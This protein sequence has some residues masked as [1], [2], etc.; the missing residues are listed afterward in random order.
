MKSIVVLNASSE[1]HCGS[2]TSLETFTAFALKALRSTHARSDTHL[3]SKATFC[4]GAGS[5]LPWCLCS[6][7]RDAH[8]PVLPRSPQFEY[9]L[10]VVQCIPCLKVDLDVDH[11]YDETATIGASCLVPLPLWNCPTPRPHS[12]VATWPPVLNILIQGFAVVH[13]MQTLPEGGLR[14]GGNWP[15]A[16]FCRLQSM[17]LGLRRGEPRRVRRLAS[18]WS[19]WDHT[20]LHGG[21]AGRLPLLPFGLCCRPLAAERTAEQLV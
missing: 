1:F 8:G 17:E 13:S 6:V 18:T 15:P 4:Q 11:A 21:G 12:P 5:F 7:R 10:S 19:I 16:V 9:E 3:L 20:W 2:C 14:P